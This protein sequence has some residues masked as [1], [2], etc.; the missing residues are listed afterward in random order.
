MGII[1]KTYNFIM[2]LI[3]LTIIGLVLFVFFAAKWERYQEEKYTGKREELASV[4]A[5]ES[6]ERGL[7]DLADLR[8]DYL[9]RCPINELTVLEGEGP[10]ICAAM[11]DA[12][13]VQSQQREMT[14]SDH[15]EL[16]YRLCALDAKEEGYDPDDYCDRQEVADETLAAAIS[17]ALCAFDSAWVFDP[18]YHT[19]FSKRGPDVYVDHELQVDCGTRLVEYSY[20]DTF[21][22]VMPEDDGPWPP[23]VEQVY[24]ALESGDH[25][26]AIAL[27]PEFLTR[28]GGTANFDLQ[29][30]NQPLSQAIEA[31]SP[32]AALLLLKSGADPLRPGSS[33]DSPIVA[34]ASY[35]MLDVVRA[36]VANGADVDGV[37]GS[38]SLDFGEP[39]RWAAWNG[40]AETARWLLENGALIAPGDP[41]RYPLWSDHTLLDDAVVG[42]DLAVI[43][44]LIEMGARSEDPPRLFRGAAEGGNPDVMLLLFDEGYEMP[45]V[46]HH[47]RIYDAVVDVIKEE[48]RGRVEHGVRMF[49]ILLDRGL[50]MSEMNDSGW[51]YGHQAVIH[52]GPPTVGFDSGEART[53]VVHEYRLRFV[54]RVIDEV[55]ASGMDID[56]R[57]EGETML[58]EAADNGQPQL[59]RYLLDLGAD[60]TLRNDDGRSALDIAASTGRRLISF[61]D[62][63]EDL[64]N[65]FA[66]V[67]EMLGGSRDLL[68]PPEE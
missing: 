67:I 2:G 32:E 52:Y 17:V 56:Q 27:L 35:G 47:D 8:R 19:Q 10:E 33:G 14:L 63:N 64:E 20:R 55:L 26:T 34:A 62:E 30:Y 3:G 37:A 1:S 41:S 65:R 60:A 61:W 51:N 66:E 38:E 12:L 49:E 39:L 31:Q 24:E 21:F 9:A 22:D 4:V 15:V 28:N 5:K 7:G 44:T 48:G 46:K 40:H 50:D 18:R 25:E 53:A 57:Y 45:D 23:I 13:L 6:R 43:E 59:V 54:K 16:G 68:N 36:L 11:A 42:G 58:M 29:Y